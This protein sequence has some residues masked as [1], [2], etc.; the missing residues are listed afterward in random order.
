MA[1][2][3]L[4][5]ACC[6]AFQST[7]GTRTSLSVTI[8]V[9]QKRNCT[10]MRRLSALL[11]CALSASA[12]ADSGTTLDIGRASQRSTST[13]ET[14]VGFGIGVGPGYLGGG[15]TRWGVGPLVEANFANGVFVS[16]TD[17]IGYRFLEDRSGFSMAASLGPSGSRREKDGED[18]DLN[19]LRGMGDV[20]VRAQANLFANYDT[21]P[22]HAS[23]GLHQTLG[24]RRGTGLDVIGS[25][26][27]HADRDNLVRASAGF[28]YANRSLMQTFFGVNE[29]QAANTGYDTYTPSAGIAG[30]GV[31]VSWRH[32]FSREW[33]GS[34]GASVINLRGSA[35]DSPLTEKRM[36]AA[37]GLSLGYRF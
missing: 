11:L 16:T 17:G 28:S 3:T 20:G 5:L 15:R 24:S 4:R 23:V 25:Y 37:L 32:A 26:D 34:V 2:A 7:A 35:A 18:G 13:P 19:R 9:K 6:F 12:Y 36:N 29:T 14:E 10:M 33:V 21:G 8:I 1:S 22:Y 31:G 27:L 30:T